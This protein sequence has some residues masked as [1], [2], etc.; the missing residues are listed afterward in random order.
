MPDF[1]FW[2]SETAERLCKARDY[3]EVTK[4]VIQV[5][6]FI[7]ISVK[8]LLTFTFSFTQPLTPFY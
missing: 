4:R 8:E 3:P 1:K 7:A 5:G 6:R 2:K